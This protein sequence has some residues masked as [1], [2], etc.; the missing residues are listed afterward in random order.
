MLFGSTLV[1][2]YSH[3]E[4]GLAVATVDQSGLCHEHEV[5]RCEILLSV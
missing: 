2:K 5:I 3:R 1:C 4:G